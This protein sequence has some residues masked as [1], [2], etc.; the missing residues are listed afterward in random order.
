MTQNDWLELFNA[1]FYLSTAKITHI[2]A[3]FLN[4][5]CNL[6]L[7]S[8]YFDPSIQTSRWDTILQG[9]VCSLISMGI[10][11]IFHYLCE[12][13][14]ICVH[15]ISVKSIRAT[16]GHIFAL[17]V[18]L[19]C[20]TFIIFFSIYRDANFWLQNWG[21]SELSFI[22]VLHP[23]YSLL[24]GLTL[25]WLREAIVGKSWMQSGVKIIFKMDDAMLTL[26]LS[27]LARGSHRSQ[28]DLQIKITDQNVTD[29]KI[30]DQKVKPTDLQIKP[31]LSDPNASQSAKKSHRHKSKDELSQVLSKTREGASH[32]DSTSGRRKNTELDNTADDSSNRVSKQTRE[33]GPSVKRSQSK[34]YEAEISRSPSSRSRSDKRSSEKDHTRVKDKRQQST[35]D[36]SRRRT[37]TSDHPIKSRSSSSSNELHH[38]SSRSE[39][40]RSKSVRE[41]RQV[42]RS[43]SH[44]HRS[45]GTGSKI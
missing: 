1:C 39:F 10:S 28:Q 26:I 13:F 41:G 11:I 36:D 9:S 20:S 5:F 2:T 21:F 19:A 18:S 14:P 34:N 42:E 29:Q 24:Q 35:S 25:H 4:V 12:S 7:N 38:T 6:T 31:T 3:G 22:F 43:Q 16:L 27:F 44:S 40:S 30:A 45:K 23:L 37:T 15:N 8:L 17:V 32:S 33:G